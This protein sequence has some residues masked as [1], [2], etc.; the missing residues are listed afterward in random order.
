MYSPFLET[1]CDPIL[2]D[3]I[4]IVQQQVFSRVVWTFFISY[5]D[6]NQ[7]VAAA[8]NTSAVIKL[9][10]AVVNEGNDEAE[11]AAEIGPTGA[12]AGA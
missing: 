6:K 2:H 10:A 3:S 1:K 7:L 9:M 12:G 5:S 4:N 11:T 8:I